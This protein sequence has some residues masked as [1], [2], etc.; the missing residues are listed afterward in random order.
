MADTA[1]NP[2]TN[3][4]VRLEGNEWIPTD[5]ATNPETG[6]VA[7]FDGKEW[8]I[9][10]RETTQTET[11]PDV[12]AESTATPAATPVVPETPAVPQATD[13]EKE[14]PNWLM[15][16]IL[17]PISSAQMGMGEARVG[18]GK[19]AANVAKETAQLPATLA[20]AAAAV[21][22]ADET[23]EAVQGSDIGQTY[24]NFFKEVDNTLALS[25]DEKTAAELASLFVGLGIGSKLLGGGAKYL[26]K[27]YG[28]KKAD[29]IAK[30][31]ASQGITATPKAILAPGRTQQAAIKTSQ[32]V[33][34]GTGIAATAVQI[35]PE[36]Q[37]VS[38]LIATSPEI[39]KEYKKAVAEGNY[40]KL[41]T[42]ER[43][44]LSVADTIANNLSP[45]IIEA[46]KRFQIN[47]NDTVS[48]KVLK[49]W[50]EELGLSIPIYALLSGIGLVVKGG[51]K[52]VSAAFRK[53]TEKSRQAVEE[54]KVTPPEGI[55][56]T[57]LGETP[58]G[59]TTKTVTDISPAT[60][61]TVVLN[62]LQQR[63]KK[64]KLLKHLRVK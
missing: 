26:I 21:V 4:A 39:Q 34:G 6:E 11:K 54:S 36:A 51:A 43:Y 31:L 12:A 19:I 30:E 32:V 7:I 10:K 62:L 23:I 18:T 24:T 61:E 28:K 1:Y 50:G 15:R 42:A 58:T 55:K 8:V 9:R 25:K 40:E 47:E 33:G 53:Y 27:R 22:G 37:F 49:R 46:A 41:P 14:Q 16:N 48:E 56:E 35:D 20:T 13:V 57:V 63:L 64:Q 2:Q 45:E 59:G 3:E 17:A 29:D 5:V 52:G 38:S 60:K 44:I